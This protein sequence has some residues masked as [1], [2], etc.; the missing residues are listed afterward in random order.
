M[1]IIKLKNTQICFC[2]GQQDQTLFLMNGV[3]ISTKKFYSIASMQI[4]SIDAIFKRTEH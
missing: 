3:S 1:Q 2:F 4:F